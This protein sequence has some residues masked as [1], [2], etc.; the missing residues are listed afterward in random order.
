[1]FSLEI[2]LNTGWNIG[3]WS[4]NLQFIDREIFSRLF[5]LLKLQLPH[6]ESRANNAYITELFVQL[7]STVIVKNLE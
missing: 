3:S 7:N 6:S 1:M 5:I 2:A 4:R